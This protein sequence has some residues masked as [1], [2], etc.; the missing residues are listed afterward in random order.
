MYAFILKKTEIISGSFLASIELDAPVKAPIQLKTS[1]EQRLHAASV[2]TK[3][4]AE[5]W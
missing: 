1:T 2:G 4:N 3:P 5:K